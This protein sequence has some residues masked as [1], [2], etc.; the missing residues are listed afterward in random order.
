MSRADIL[1][2]LGRLLQNLMMENNSK[3]S[4]PNSQKCHQEFAVYIGV[5]FHRDGTTLLAISA[6]VSKA[7]A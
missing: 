3:Q 4:T 1:V 6:G 5:L 7:G 2:K